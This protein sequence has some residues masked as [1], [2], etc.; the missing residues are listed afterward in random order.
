VVLPSGAVCCGLTWISTGQLGVARRVARRSLDRLRPHLDAGALVVGL[1]PSCTAVFRTDL[2]ELLPGDDADRLAGRTRTLAEL[3]TGCGWEPPARSGDA[4]L[5]VHCHQ[6]AVLGSAADERLLDRI[7]L[8]RQPLEPS[9]CG[10]AGN[11]GFERGHYAVAQAVGERVLLPAV[12]AA[13]E[14]TV[15]LA[16]GFSCRT[17]IAHG[18]GRRALHLAELLA[19]DLHERRAGGVAERP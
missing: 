12:R 8:A 14:E 11:F 6:R 1:E 9:C 15:L 19:A 16:D 5:Q 4:L 17:Q 10:L 18:T 7:G 13:S 2:P 3:L